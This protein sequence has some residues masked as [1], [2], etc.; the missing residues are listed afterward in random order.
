M[1]S[2]A[3]LLL[4]PPERRSPVLVGWGFG[5]VSYSVYTRWKYA[6]ENRTRTVNPVFCRYIIVSYPDS[7]PLLHFGRKGICNEPLCG[8][9]VRI[10]GYTSRVPG[11]DSQRYQNILGVA[12]L[13][14]GP[15]TLVKIIKEV[16]E[17]N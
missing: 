10:P 13:E 5:W 8:L 6:A 17:R 14:L 3:P 11:Y 12:R 15:L 16:L 9:V 7:Y 1:I 2:F 4:Y